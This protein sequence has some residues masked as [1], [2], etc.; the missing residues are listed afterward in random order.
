MRRKAKYEVA[1]LYLCEVQTIDYDETKEEIW[2]FLQRKE[3]KKLVPLNDAVSYYHIKE[4]EPI[5]L[6]L[7]KTKKKITME[8]MKQ[9]MKTKDRMK[10]QHLQPSTREEQLEDQ[11]QEVKEVVLYHEETEYPFYKAKRKI[12]TS[13]D[14][15]A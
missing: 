11:G 15:V 7:E 4:K 5:R 2:P 10:E 14:K 12:R 3:D 13:Y 8:E 9:A 1:N 6:Y